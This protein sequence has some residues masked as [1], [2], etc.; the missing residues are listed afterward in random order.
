MNIVHCKPITA[1]L[2]A[3]CMV[4]I[5]TS[6]AARQF[7]SIQA[8]ATPEQAR[9]ALPPGA[10]PVAKIAPLEREEVEPLVRRVVE[11]WNTPEMEQTLGRAL[12]DKSRLLDTMDAAVPRDAHLSLQ[13]VQGIR[14]V[15][16]YVI[17]ATGDRTQSTV[18]VVSAQVRAQLEFNSANGFRRLTGTNEL[19]LR[20]TKGG[21]K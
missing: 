20:I 2:L 19:L 9:Q 14:T 4:L 6:T 1:L 7:R 13:S 12:Y 16:Q 21:T 8:I 17:P 11:S 18:S 3:S 10:Q 15:E 5:S